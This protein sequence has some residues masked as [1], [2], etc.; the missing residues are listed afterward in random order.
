MGFGISTPA[1]VRGVLDAGAAGAISGS[2]VVQLHAG[3]TDRKAVV[4][5]LKDFAG[6]MRDATFETEGQE[7]TI[8]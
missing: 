6:A 3:R 8:R 1:H 2:A 7:R 4:L 5:D